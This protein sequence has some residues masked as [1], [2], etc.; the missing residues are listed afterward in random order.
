MKIVYSDKKSGKTSQIE[1][2]KDIEP[3]LIG[4]R[5]GEVI[6]G[7]VFGMEGYK[8]QITG[9]S[10]KMGVPSR[11]ELE[12]GRK[13]YLLLAKGPGIIGAKKGKRMRKLIRGN[14]INTE[15]GQINSVIKR[16]STRSVDQLQRGVQRGIIVGEVA[17]LAHLVV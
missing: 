11:K 1:I 3:M 12:G 6:E 16:G 9:L 15:T 4:K 2:P 10:D 7:A 17:H 8:F 5:I 13:A 14:T